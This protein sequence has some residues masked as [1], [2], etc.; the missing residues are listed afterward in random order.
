MLVIGFHVTGAHAQ[1]LVLGPCSV[2]CVFACAT[3]VEDS[4][5]TLQGTCTFHSTIHCHLQSARAS[6]SSCAGSLS[7]KSHTALALGL[8]DH[9]ERQAEQQSSRPEGEWAKV[10]CDTIHLES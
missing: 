8:G 9:N 4:L 5:T 6:P 2:S 7:Q 3:V 1:Y 10:D